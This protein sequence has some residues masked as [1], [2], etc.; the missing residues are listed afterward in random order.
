MY[1]CLVDPD[2]KN[3]QAAGLTFPLGVFPVEPLEPVAGYTME[4]EAADGAEDGSDLEEWPDRYVLDILLSA[5]RLPALVVQL[6]GLMPPRIYPILD[7]IGHDEFREI[8]PYI[9]YDQIGVDLFLDS[10]RQFRGFFYED[11]MVGF[12]AM[13]EAPFF[14]MFV[15]EHK[16]L[17]L[18]VEPALKD[19][20]ERLLEAFDLDM[21]PELVG[22]DTVSHEHRSVLIMPADRPNA[23]S[24]EEV[25]AHLRLEWRL[26]L[27]VNPEHN[28]DDEGRELGLTAWQAMLRCSESEDEKPR[29][30]EVY[31]WATCLNEAE[32][33]AL[34][35]VNTVL[36]EAGQEDWFDVAVLGMDRLGDDRLRGLVEPL[37]AEAS[38]RSTHRE[39]GVIHARWVE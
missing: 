24:P 29:L 28:L 25:V 6:I 11:G 16:I 17:T 31:L 34:G 26:I 12:G 38:S 32:E 2:L 37:G 36:S 22:V 8:D 35:A 20:V 10:L 21:H 14:Y 39:P 19:R 18:R 9:S 30:A 4:F 3:V 15:D 27:N 7:F 1:T 33:L 13:S 5:E 23:L